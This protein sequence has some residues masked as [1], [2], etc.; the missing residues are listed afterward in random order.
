MKKQFIKDLPLY[1]NS[2]SVT[3]LAFE[4]DLS[5]VSRVGL[6]I[7]AALSFV[8]YCDNIEKKNKL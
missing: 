3:L 6:F 4:T 5:T 1:L 7:I 2:I 8:W